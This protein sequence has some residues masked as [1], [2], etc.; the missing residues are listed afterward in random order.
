MKFFQFTKKIFEK[1]GIIPDRFV[2][3]RPLNQR[4]LLML[5]LHCLSMT[6]YTLFLF[7]EAKTFD[8]YANGAFMTT[9]VISA[10]FVYAVC[11]WNRKPYVTH[12]KRLE[13]AINESTNIFFLQIS[14]TFTK[15]HHH[16]F[17]R[18]KFS[19]LEVNLHHIQ[20]I[21]GTI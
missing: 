15:Y 11:F 4:G 20:R 14:F 9:A 21:C 16:L 3:R 6:S 7:F 2:I 10:F 12:M 8:E 13:S 17:R 5:F 1:F 18:A 19:T